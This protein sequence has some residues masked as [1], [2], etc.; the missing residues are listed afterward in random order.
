M[1]TLAEAY[2][3]AEY[4]YLRELYNEH[5]VDGYGKMA[6]IAGVTRNRM[7]DM[8][9]KHGLIKT[10]HKNRGKYKPLRHANTLHFNVD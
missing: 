8:L 9:Y 10:T 2:R 6:E 7:I 5:I 1:R 4:E 3:Q